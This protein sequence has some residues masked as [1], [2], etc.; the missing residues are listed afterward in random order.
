M[1]LLSTLEEDNKPTQNH[2]F[3]V[4]PNTHH[5]A[6]TFPQLKKSSPT[7]SPSSPIPPI[8]LLRLPPL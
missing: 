7:P 4:P 1:H 2:G 6:T 3:C 5:Q 8:A